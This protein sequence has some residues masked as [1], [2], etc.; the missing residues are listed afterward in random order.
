MVGTPAAQKVRV[1]MVN[2]V[3]AM[4]YIAMEFIVSFKG[5]LTNMRR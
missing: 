4:R 2:T 5:D 1:V 3:F